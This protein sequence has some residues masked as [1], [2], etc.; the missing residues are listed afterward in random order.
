M[1]R[2]HFT[3]VGKNPNPRGACLCSP[4]HLVGC[5]GPYIVFSHTEMLDARQPAPVLS[6]ACATEALRRANR[7]TDVPP[8]PPVRTGK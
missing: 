8:P 2:S 7:R 1:P 6:V 4:T 5:K 3:T